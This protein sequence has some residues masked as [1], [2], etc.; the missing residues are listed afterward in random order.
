MTGRSSVGASID[1]TYAEVRKIRRMFQE[2]FG[3]TDCAE[4]LGLELDTEEGQR[5]FHEN[6]L[7]EKCLGYTEEATRMA[8]AL[9]EEGDEG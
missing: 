1:A 3:A 8:I 2:E 7:I 9:L 5:I 6:N 4:L